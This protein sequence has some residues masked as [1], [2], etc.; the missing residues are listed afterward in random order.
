MHR[1]DDGID[2]GR[3]VLFAP[4]FVRLF[5]NVV[6]VLHGTVYQGGTLWE[7][8]ECE[9]VLYKEGMMVLSIGNQS[10]ADVS[11][12]KV[13]MQ[14]TCIKHETLVLYSRD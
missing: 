4:H 11:T 14:Q 8:I 6:V 13:L 2:I 1:R 12:I 10:S 9:A 5:F 7:V 3:N